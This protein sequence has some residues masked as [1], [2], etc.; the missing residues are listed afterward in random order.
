MCVELTTVG[1]EGSSGPSWGWW[2]G[3]GNRL[4]A[5]QAVKQLNRKSV[6]SCT[7]HVCMYV[8]VYIHIFIYLYLYIHTHMCDICIY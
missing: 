3:A 2:G 1:D 6:Q 5:K 4:Q 8:Y 7:L